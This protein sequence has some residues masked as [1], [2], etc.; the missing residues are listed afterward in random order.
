MPA[1]IGKYTL[2]SVISSGSMGTLYKSVD[3][4]TQRPVA[5]KTVRHELLA[6]GDDDFRARLRAEMQAAHALTH[7]GIV[8]VY[9]Y[10]EEDDCAYMSMEYVEGQSL[11]Q[12]FERKAPFSIARA[13][14]IMSQLLEALQHAHDRGVWHRDIKPSNILITSEGRVKVTDFGIARLSSPAVTQMDA[15]MGTP[16]YIAPETYLT[17]TFDHRVDVF[18][19]GAVCYQLLAGV[20]PF[21]GTADKIMFDVCHETPSP[22]SLAG[23]SSSLRRFDAVVLQALALNPDDRFA[24]AALFRDALLQTFTR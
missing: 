5:I 9:E 20:P 13:I 11:E 8:A 2:S 22:P 19:A 10:G 6:V 15:I 18:A 7:P 1:R 21:T 14:D 16:G 3:P 12:C 17:D 23:A 4:D 24:T